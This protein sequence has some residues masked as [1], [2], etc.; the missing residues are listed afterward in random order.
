[1][2]ARSRRIALIAAAAVVV[3]VLL[4]ALAVPYLVDV[5]RYR[6]QVVAEIEARTGK[7][8]RIG[9]LAITVFPRLSIRVEDFEL[10]NPPGYPPGYFV[11]ARRIDAILDAG[12]LL[13]RQVKITSLDLS[14][15]D[16]RMISGGHGHW[17]Y[18]SPGAGSQGSRASADPPAFSLGV[19]STITI[20]HGQWTV[21]EL[22]PSG[23]AGPAYLEAEDVSSELEDVDLAAFSPS[24]SSRA[25]LRSVPA[26]E[27]GGSWLVSSAYAAD[28]S[29]PAAAH[30]RLSA[31]SVRFGSLQG[32]SFKT[33]FTVSARGAVFDNIGVSLDGG[34]AE[35]KLTLDF[36]SSN[37]RYTATLKVHGVDM[38]RL[39][40]SFPQSRGK[41][42]GTL[43]GSVSLNGEI[44]PTA[45]ALSLV[46]GSGQAAVRNGKLP[47]LELNKNL[48]LLARLASLG[49]AQGD[50]SSFS[51]ITADFEIA[52]SLLHSRNVKIIGNGAD[53]DGSG[54]L[55]LAGAGELDYTGV[56]SVASGQTGLTGVVTALSGATYSNGRLS[57]P[58]GLKGTL[59]NPR[60][61][62]RSLSGAKGLQGFEKMLATPQS[63]QSN[64]NSN[65]LIQG[66]TNLFG[67]KK[68]KQPPK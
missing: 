31:K 43:D 32:T 22:L 7:P 61:S 24:G 64:Q 65:S 14:Q 62:L 8:A 45:D 68:T 18:E 3:L 60:F 48:M 39:L 56:A 12:A 1:M 63:G 46:R 40:E 52:N 30:G 66:I 5:N 26:G 16:I 29:G 11:K 21:A 28:A 15:P 19:I 47:S 51:S 58:F 35:G 13:H 44:P 4:A 34:A 59:E 9:H 25:G 6:P 38:A 54:T 17:N 42:T 49:P 33:D 23:R 36:S 20:G 27:G 55:N 57:F 41:M 53:V 10:D 50:P 67:K 37:L 2:T